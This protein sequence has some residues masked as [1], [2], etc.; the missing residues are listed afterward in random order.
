MRILTG[1]LFILIF[2]SI[3]TFLFI[4]TTKELSSAQSLHNVLDEAI[5]LDEVTLTNNSTI[6]DREGHIISDV[7][8]GENRIQLPFSEIPTYV[9]EAFI[10]AEDHSFYE[11]PGFDMSGIARALFINIQSSSVE[12]GGSTVTQQLARNLYLNHSQTYERKLTE[13]LYSYHLE[14][15]LSKQEIMEMYVNS[16]YFANGVYG[17]EAAS[18]FYFSKSTSELSLAQIAFLSSIPNSPTLYNPLMNEE[19]THERKEWMLTKM[20]EQRFINEKQFN[21]A[22]SEKIS[23]KVVEKHDQFPDYVTYVFHELEQLVAKQEGYAQRLRAATSNEERIVIHDNLKKRVNELLTGGLIIETALNPHIQQH[24]VTTI[25][26]S[27]GDAQIQG[28][29]SIIDHDQAEIVAITGGTDYQKFDFHRGYQ[30]FRQPGSAFKPL[31]VYGPLFEE[32]NLSNSSVIDAGPIKRGNYEPENFGNAVYEKV[33]IEEAFKNSYNTA[34]VR[35]LDMVGIEPA[36]SYLNQFDFTQISAED[37][38]LPA[39]LGGLSHGVSVNELTQAYSVFSTRGIYR[40]PRA[41]RE[42][43]DLNGNVLYAWGSENKEIWSQTTVDQMKS[44]LSSVVSDGTGQPANIAGSS[45]V[46]GKTGTTND[47]NDLWFVGSTERYTSGIWLG[48]DEPSSIYEY[49]QRNLH[50]HLWRE[51]MTGLE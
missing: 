23:L 18:Q 38:I 40:S 46:G 47:F 31:L 37:H 49:S 8:A 7:Y 50:T 51:I 44:L 34:A 30:A 1:N 6:L 42:V 17:I 16:I 28:A 11:H 12:Q 10:A 14:R 3:F 36:F 48:R 26:A 27:L 19:Q 20:H 33:S 25:N 4:Q 2:I 15:V 43:S 41:I 22:M 45:Y 39:A 21:A 29:A 24:A 9:I 13:L 32:T 35:I 5:E